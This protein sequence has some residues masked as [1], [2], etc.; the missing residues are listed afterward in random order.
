MASLTSVEATPTALFPFHR[1]K[2]FS[3]LTYVI[4]TFSSTRI[5]NFYH[6]FFQHDEKFIHGDVKFLPLPLNASK[7][8]KPWDTVFSQL[9]RGA[10]SE[11]REIERESIASQSLLMA[12]SHLN[13]S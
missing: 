13:S 12:L 3:T 2:I 1:V 9:C 8:Q 5:G 10:L 4:L 7:A 6:P 11:V